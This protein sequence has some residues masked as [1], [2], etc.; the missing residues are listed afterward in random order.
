MI[1]L[2]VERCLYIYIYHCIKERGREREKRWWSKCGKHSNGRKCS[3]NSSIGHSPPGSSVLGILQARI[4]E[5]VAIPFSRG[6]SQ[7]RD[8]TRASCIVGR[9][10]T[11]WATRKALCIGWASLKTVLA[12][13]LRFRGS[14]DLV[15]Q[16]LSDFLCYIFSTLLSHSCPPILALGCWPW[17]HQQVPFLGF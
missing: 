11:I 14:Y 8:Q 4:L 10:F 6:P 16:Y 1:G 12:S 17:P 9:F 5:W 7:P 13:L 2:H 15:P 3:C